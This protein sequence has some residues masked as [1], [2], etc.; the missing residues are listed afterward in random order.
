MAPR[1]T[2]F[3]VDQPVDFPVERSAASAGMDTGHG[4]RIGTAMDIGTRLYTAWHG[5]LVGQDSAGNRYYEERRPRSGRR[6]KRWVL[7]AGEIEASAVPPEWFGWLHY[8]NDLPLPETKRHPWQ[9]PY[10]PNLTGTPASYRP[11][12]HDYRGGHR[13]SATGD[14]EAWTPGS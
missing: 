11:P 6:Q 4:L 13:P 10:Q 7:Y 5:R 14:Y 2:K 1:V 3:S 9:K 12:G 8:T